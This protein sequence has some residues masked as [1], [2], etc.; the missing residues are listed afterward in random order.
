MIKGKVVFVLHSHLPYV[1][2]HGKWPH[3]MDWINEAAA[4]TYIPLIQVFEKLVQ[5]G[6]SP[7]VT[8]GITPVLSEMLADDVFKSEFSEYLSQKIEA[9]GFD[10]GEF[11]R[12][13]DGKR[14]DIA[15]MW[16]AF[17]RDTKSFFVERLKTD[18]VGAFKRLQD[19]GHIEVDR[20]SVV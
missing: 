6:I 16:E 2:S 14:H 17:Y 18:I 3:G 7:K 20:K 12:I 4:E 15:R 11:Y 8:I 1:L 9:A 10:A 19:D 13:G 5:E